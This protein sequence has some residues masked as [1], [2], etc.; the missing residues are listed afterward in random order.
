MRSHANMNQITGVLMLLFFIGIASA[1][2]RVQP[3]SLASKST[4]SIAD[5]IK[6]TVTKIEQAGFVVAGQYSPYVNTHI[7]A[8]TN[9][10]LKQA[11]TYSERGGYGAVL[12]ASVTRNNETTEVAFTNPI[13][14]AA[15]YRMNA[16]FEKQYE[17][18][19]TH[20][21]FVKE[22]GAGDKILTQQDMRKYHYTVMMEYFDDPSELAEYGSHTEAVQKVEAN[23]DAGKGASKKVYRIDL[24]KDEE[25]KQMTLFGMALNGHDEK[26]CSADQFIMSRIDKTTPRQ[27]A[28]LPY[29]ILVYGDEVEALFARFRIAISWPHLSMMRSET[30]ATFFKIMCAPGA[31]ED[32]LKE[33]A[34]AY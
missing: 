30:G 18:L 5:E 25:D 12:R 6:A 8:F 16:N 24:G 3:F 1:E 26:D 22:F 19:K 9:D 17:A 2:Q 34:G 15:A 23:L 33:I 29:E 32:T 31:I 21:G 11:A 28:H 14:W 4:N 20:L 7:I 10:T 27:S 13:Y